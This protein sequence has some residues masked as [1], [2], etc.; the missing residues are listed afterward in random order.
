MV[1]LT[2]NT[3]EITYLEGENK[4]NIREIEDKIYNLEDDELITFIRKEFMPKSI[5]DK[6]RILNNINTLKQ[7]KKGS[8]IILKSRIEKLEKSFEYTT[9]FSVFSGFALALVASYNTIMKSIDKEIDSFI[10]ALCGF[11]L[12]IAVSIIFAYQIGKIQS[13]KSMAIYFKK[14]IDE[15]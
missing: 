7:L 14:I 8:K 9:F 4:V 2:D 6:T 10:T 5:T 13:K 1:I 12:L 3:L 15:M 11:V